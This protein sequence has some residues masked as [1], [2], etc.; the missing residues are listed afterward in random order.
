MKHISKGGRIMKYTL[1]MVGCMLTMQAQAAIY[2]CQGTA[3]ADGR[4]NKVYQDSPCTTRT[5]GQLAHVPEAPLEDQQRVQ[6]SIAA[7]NAQY[8]QRM[9]M[10]EQER[11]MALEEQRQNLALAV[12]RERLAQLEAQALENSRPVF[13]YWPRVRG[14]GYRP[15]K[16]FIHQGSHQGRWSDVRHRPAGVGVSIE[17]NR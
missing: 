15:Q 8:I 11:Q 12:E 4:Q 13:V 16:P 3:Q 6:K 10:V 14:H 7:A 9:Q 1:A 17:Y 2:I 5:I